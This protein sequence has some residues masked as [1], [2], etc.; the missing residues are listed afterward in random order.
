MGGG[1]RVYLPDS[2]SITPIQGA[3]SCDP[4]GGCCTTGLVTII[5]SLLLGKSACVWTK[6]DRNIYWLYTAFVT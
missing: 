3:M 6:V 1:L 2:C 4:L 5:V